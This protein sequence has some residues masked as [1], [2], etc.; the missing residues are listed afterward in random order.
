MIFQFPN[1]SKRLLK[2]KKVSKKDCLCFYFSKNCRFVWAVLSYL[3]SP[4]N[5]KEKDYG[6]NF[7]NGY[8][9]V[10]RLLLASERFESIQS[11]NSKRNELAVCFAYYH[12][13]HSRHF[14]KAYFGSDQLR[15]DCLHFEFGNCLFE[16]NCIF[17]QRFA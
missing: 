12:R 15:I 8:A 7:R 3:R 5:A 10:L 6:I 14:C 2:V 17:P 1:L 16:R 13:L 4:N 9:C 11:K